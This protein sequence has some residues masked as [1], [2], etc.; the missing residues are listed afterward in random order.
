MLSE[1]AMYRIHRL[2]QYRE[3]IQRNELLPGA[4]SM[5]DQKIRFAGLR[6]VH[7]RLLKLEFEHYELKGVFP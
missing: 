5:E 3:A 2:E 1:H 6:V 7:D 4:P